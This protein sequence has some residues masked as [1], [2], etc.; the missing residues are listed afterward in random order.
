MNYRYL[1]VLILFS[2]SSLTYGQEQLSM[3]DCIRIALDANA[4][5][6]I[7]RAQLEIAHLR[8]HGAWTGKYPQVGFNINSQGS[9]ADQQ[10]PASFLNGIIRSGNATFSLDA[11][12]TV[13]QGLRAKKLQEQAA[14]G[15]EQARERVQATSL[16]IARNVALA[17]LQ[18]EWQDAQIELAREAL[19]L[20]S[21][22][23]RY[24]Q[25]RQALGQSSRQLILQSRDAM[26][27]DSSNLIL[28]ELNARMAL[29]NLRLAM[30]QPDRTSFQLV[31]RLSEELPFNLTVN[32]NEILANHPSLR[33]A[34]LGQEVSRLQTRIQQSAYY[35]RINVLGGLVW[36]GNVTGLDGNN[37]FT[38]EAFGVRTGTNKNTYAG[39]QLALPLYDGSLRNR[40][41]QEARVQ[42]EVARWNETQISQQ[43]TAQLETLNASAQSQMVLLDLS[44][45]QHENAR[46]NLT[47]SD[48]RY[49][50]GQLSIFDLRTIQL[51]YI[52]AGLRRITALYNLRVTEAEIGS[53]TGA[54]TRQ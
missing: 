32:R 2:F 42:E 12:W 38:G 44:R 31:N 41:V 54:L 18:A 43:I 34:R 16:E 52:Q 7:S 26:L 51:G 15:E 13:Y 35:P 17:Y 49:K 23:Y 47:I 1:F 28:A 27:T 9:I 11:N 25:E 46:E 39:L 53:L 8:N 6:Q 3:A 45:E 22:L 50:M 29:V 5:N 14:K 36:S 21:D 30:G 48:E 10:N 33:E 19:S 20:S 40:Q 37:P 24:Q 4:Q